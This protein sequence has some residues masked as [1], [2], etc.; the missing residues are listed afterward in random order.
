M[1]KRIRLSRAKGWRMPPNTV[2]VDRSTP[3]G[4]PFITGKDGT[5]LECVRLYIIMMTGRLC[6]SSDCVAQERA[7]THVAGHLH[8]LKGKNLACWCSIGTPC[9]AE[10]LLLLANYS[11]SVASKKIM[12]KLA[13]WLTENDKP[14][15]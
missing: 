8:D 4:N 7:Y 2:K 12:A 13:L 10:V 1:T 9:H 5:Q 15:D 6:L 11:K 14:N 3:W